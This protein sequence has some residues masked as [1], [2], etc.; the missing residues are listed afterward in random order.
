VR[1]PRT[2]AS[3]PRYRYVAVAGALAASGWFDEMADILE[4]FQ[5]IL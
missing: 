5:S 1:S 3:S 2:K 4:I